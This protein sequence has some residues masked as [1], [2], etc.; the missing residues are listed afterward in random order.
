MCG[1]P[2]VHYAERMYRA[3]PKP[4]CTTCGSV[5]VSRLGE[6]TSENAVMLS[7]YDHDNL[8]VEHKFRLAARVC[9]DCGTVTWAVPP[10]THA[11]LRQKWE[12]I[13]DRDPPAR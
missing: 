10:R 8:G 2:R 4:P 13:R 1:T 6:V 3:P 11:E 9:L 5:N 12:H 7:F